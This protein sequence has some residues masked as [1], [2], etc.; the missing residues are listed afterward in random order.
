MKKYNVLLI[1]V[2]ML[3]LVILPAGVSG[4]Q[5]RSALE[6]QRKELENQIK[7]TQDIL[8]KTLKS[9]TKSLSELN[10]LTAQIRQRQELL[11]SIKTELNK[12]E[13]ESSV[14][15]KQKSETIREIAQLES[16][17][18]STLRSAYVR[19]R[20]QPSWLYILSAQTA[21]QALQR[22]V[23]LRQYNNYVRRQ[24]QILSGKKA[25]L[26]EVLRQLAEDRKVKTELFQT[27][28]RTKSQIQKEQQSRQAL[29][30]QLSKEEKKL[31]QQLTASQEKKKKLDAEIA[32]LIKEEAGKLSSSGL[33]DA[34]ETKALNAQFSSN[35]G[36]LPWPVGKG[37]ITGRFGEHPHPVLKGIK[38]QNNGVDIRAEPNSAVKSLFEGTVASVTRIPGYD[39]MIMIRHGL[40]YTVYSKVDR[41]TVK[42][43][44]AITTGQVIGYLGSDDPELHLEIWQ[45]KNKLNPETWLAK[46]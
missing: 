29:V 43:G 12:V 9:K 44:D 41:V 11:E 24:W 13:Q 38:V 36:K 4:Q 30:N 10:A 5:D 32:R 20:L 27:E 21:G 22:W 15:E 23:Y 1:C 42:K 45:D 31:K 17:L 25:V 46:K 40:Y 2:F 19:N 26:E 3:G 35:K 6:K 34:P 18:S 14:R 7:N 37:L 16:R 33:A 8:Q 28:E 39:N